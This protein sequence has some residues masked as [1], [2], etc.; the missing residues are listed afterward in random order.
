MTKR[1]I[2]LGDVLEVIADAIP[3]EPA[4]ITNEVNFTYAQ[5]D[6]RVTRLANHLRS[7]GIRRGEHVGV[8]AQNCH[9]WVEAFYA[10]AKISAVP[11]NVNY[12]YV[13]AELRYLYDNADCVAV[14]VAPEYVDAV[15]DVRDALPNLRN[16]LVMGEEYE[17]A[18]AAASPVRWVR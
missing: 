17:S 14:I 13:E 3:N 15:N 12:R 9:E 11:V 18:L 6:E 10:C 5:L 7:I 8:H 4:L 16:L 2:Q 1:H